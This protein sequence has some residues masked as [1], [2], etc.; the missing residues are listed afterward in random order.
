MAAV[1]ILKGAQQTKEARALVD[2][3]ISRKGQQAMVDAKT[4][5][6]PVRNDVSAGKGVPSLGEIK[7]VEAEPGFASKNRKRLVDRW[8]KDVLGQ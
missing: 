2:W 1:S 8:L 4:Y 3:I 6:L 7:L 5:F